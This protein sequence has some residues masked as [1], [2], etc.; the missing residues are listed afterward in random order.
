MGRDF[1]RFP[2]SCF[3]VVVV[4]V[5]GVVEIVV[6]VV[7]GVGFGFELGRQRVLFVPLLSL[8]AGTEWGLKG[9]VGPCPLAS[10]HPMALAGGG[11]RHPD[12]ATL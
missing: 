6:V 1:G 9:G 8:N 4:K 11:C 3:V 5:V 7:V 12:F 2:G 10:P